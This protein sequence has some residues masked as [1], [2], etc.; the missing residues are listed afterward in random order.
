MCYENGNI[1]VSVETCSFANN[2]A[3]SVKNYLQFLL[4]EGVC[5][6][7]HSPSTGHRCLPEC[8]FL[9]K[10]ARNKKKGC[11]QAATTGVF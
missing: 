5:F 8:L 9:M 6:L 2:S 11:R 10:L 4:N 7:Y 1:N 3:G